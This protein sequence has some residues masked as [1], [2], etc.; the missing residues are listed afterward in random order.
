MPASREEKQE[1]AH[2]AADV[3]A[4][5]AEK[6]AEEANKAEREAI[7]ADAAPGAKLCP[8]CNGVLIEHGDENPF[9]IGAKHCDNCGI[10]WASG[11]K[12]PRA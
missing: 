9:K 10:C 12:S 7:K 1:E 6:A 4:E 3:A 5:P 8:N 11:L 2:L